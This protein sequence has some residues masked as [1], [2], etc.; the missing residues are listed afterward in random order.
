MNI[1]VGDQIPEE[2]LRHC[3]GIA[4]RDVRGIANV[5]VTINDVR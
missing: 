2:K 5:L 3:M 4:Y 1:K